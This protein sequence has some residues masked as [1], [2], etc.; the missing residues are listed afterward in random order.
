MNSIV[1]AQ[2]YQLSKYEYVDRLLVVELYAMEYYKNYMIKERLYYFELWNFFGKYSLNGTIVISQEQHGL[3]IHSV[4][5]IFKYKLFVNCTSLTNLISVLVF[6]SSV[7]FVSSQQFTALQH[8]VKT[9]A[10]CR[11]CDT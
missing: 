3:V 9:P 5:V 10:S 11:E 6:L 8:M 1:L 2:G 7:S 4:P